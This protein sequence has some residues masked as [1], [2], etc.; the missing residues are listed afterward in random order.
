MKDLLKRLSIAIISWWLFWYVL[1]LFLKGQTIVQTGFSEYNMIYILVLLVSCLYLFVFF[2]V[3]PIYIKMSKV[4]LLVLGIA[5]IIMGDTVL[6]NIPDQKIYIS[7]II[8]VFGVIISLL[9]WTNVFITSKVKKEKET[10]KV[11]II[12][13]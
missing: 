9:S 12:E 13:I 2:A 10:K 8:K 6:I 4:T 5:L 3:Y 11:E 1:Y 7:D